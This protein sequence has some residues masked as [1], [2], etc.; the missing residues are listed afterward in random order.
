MPFD[1]SFH[2]PEVRVG[3]NVEF[4]IRRTV[5]LLV[6]LYGLNPFKSKRVCFT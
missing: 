5:V 4:R 6:V 2:F 3:Q 1:I